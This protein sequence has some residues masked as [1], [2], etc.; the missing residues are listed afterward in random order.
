VYLSTLFIQAAKSAV[1]T[2]HKRDD[3]CFT[4]ADT[5]ARCIGLANGHQF[6]LSIDREIDR[7]TR[8]GEPA[9]VLMIDIDHPKKIND[10]CGHAVGNSITEAVAK[11]LAMRMRP[12]VTVAR[13]GA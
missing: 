6:D 2:A 12:M 10:N 3:P 7:M 11:A 4:V 5:A 1:M 13:L 9:L 8:V